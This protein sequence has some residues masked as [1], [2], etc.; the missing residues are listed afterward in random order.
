MTVLCGRAEEAGHDPQLRA[1][2]DVAVAR[3]VGSFTEICELCLPFV[4]VG[5]HVLL[6]RGRD[7]ES[8][9]EASQKALKTLGG[10]ARIVK[11]YSLPDH[12]MEYHLTLVEKIRP[13]P[14][15]YPRRVGL[16][17]HQPLS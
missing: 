15:A 12:E 2:F 5:G 16:P 1:G 3:A 13:T 9:I 7:A 4:K 11:S 10:A 6:W 17:K 8:E 14:A